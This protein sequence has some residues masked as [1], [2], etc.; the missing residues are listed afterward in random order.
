MTLLSESSGNRVVFDSDS[1]VIR[2]GHYFGIRGPRG[3]TLSKISTILLLTG[4]QFQLSCYL[5]VHMT[6]SRTLT[7]PGPLALRIVASHR[8]LGLSPTRGPQQVVDG[9]A[10]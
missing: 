4:Q 8:P 3:D 1:T 9:I 10:I 7:R 5:Q 6:F 2:Q